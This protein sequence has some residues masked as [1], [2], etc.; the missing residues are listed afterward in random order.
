MFSAFTLS[1]DFN[2]FIPLLQTI[3]DHLKKYM[4]LAFGFEILSKHCG[5]LYNTFS[6]GKTKSK[7]AQKAVKDMSEIWKFN[8]NYKKIYFRVLM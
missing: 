7:K 8:M 3:K 4:I 2:T 1:E 5:T 6:F